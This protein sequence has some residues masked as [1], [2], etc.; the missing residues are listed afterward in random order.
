M[1]SLGEDEFFNLVNP[2]NLPKDISLEGLAQEIQAALAV[3]EKSKV[4]GLSL[5]KHVIETVSPNIQY[6]KNFAKAYVE[7]SNSVFIPGG[8]DIVEGFYGKHSGKPQYALWEKFVDLSDY[9]GV[10]NLT[11]LFY[12]KQFMEFVL[13]DEAFAANKPVMGV[14]HGL[15][16]LNVY[17]GGTIKNVEGHNGITPEL[18][19]HSQKG[20]L[21]SLVEPGMHGPSYH[22]QAIDKLG[23]GLETV[24][25]YDGVIK[26]VQSVD[27]K[28][29]IMTQFHPE[30]NADS[31]STKIMQAFANMSM[32]NALNSKALE[33]KDVLG[34][35][36][37]SLDTLLDAHSAS[38]SSTEQS[39]QVCPCTSDLE[40]T[41]VDPMMFFN[42]SI[43]D[44]IPVY[45]G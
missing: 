32:Q 40:Q 11:D 22:N 3:G 39:L 27:G 42:Q 36:H 38:E 6:F 21:G 35:E 19:I 15:Q 7:K 29:L 14:C 12:L 34:I 20:V 28:Q 33:L 44:F 1:N 18:D 26:G 10:T 2:Q 30:L 8:E 16:L 45:A 23:S 5:A 37:D 41:P 43:D 13:V 9:E 4:E 24:A 25:S 17:F 31:V